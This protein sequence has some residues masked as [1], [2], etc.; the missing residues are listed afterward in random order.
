[1]AVILKNLRPLFWLLIFGVLQ[2]IFIFI[3]CHSKIESA[4]EVLCA[5]F[6][7]I[8]F[9]LNFLSIL[10]LF[11]LLLENIHKK[12]ANAIFLSFAVLWIVLN[13]FDVISFYYLGI[14]CSINSFELFSVNDLANKASDSSIAIKA[15]A[16]LIVFVFILFKIKKEILP[17]FT[18]NKLKQKLLFG[19]IFF[20]LSLT[21]LPYP[22]NYYSHQINISNAAKQLS[23][24]SYYS[25]TKSFLHTKNEYIMNEQE[26]LASFK[27]QQG[28]SNTTDF[29]DREVNYTDMA[30][31]NVVLI[32]M[33]SF[34]ANRIGALNG[35]KHLSPHFDSLCA[36]GTLYTKCFSS[37]PRTQYGISSIFFGFPHILGYNLFRE[38]KLKHAFNGLIKLAEK[39]KYK[40]HFIHGGSAAYDDMELFLSA[41]AALTVKDVDDIKE[42]KFKNTWGVDDESLF[43]FSEKYIADNSGK[44]LFCI[45]SMTNHEPHQVP[46]DFKAGDNIK[47]LEKKESAFLYSD[48]ALG[49]FV[50]KLRHSNKYKNTLIIITGDHAEGYSSRDNETKLFH[51]PLL[52]IDHK[53]KNIKNNMICSHADI[54]EYV[55]SKTKFKGK[56]HFINHNLNN[57]K[58]GQAYYRNYNN[59]IYQVTDS[60]IYR[61]N[62]IDRSFCKLYCDSNMYVTK[63]ERIENIDPKNALILKNMKANY[64]SLQYLF[65]NGMYHAN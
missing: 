21:Y 64:T 48:Q 59:D 38:N 11:Y 19:C 63:Q 43:S 23:L 20:I 3:L 37:G 27:M 40:T 58:S 14:R 45:L 8:I 24:N 6:L 9:D 10:F 16:L 18:S 29:I 4:S 51:V 42:F 1:M 22:I 5:L 53:N 62:L 30:Y 17:D 49:T 39:N 33:E 57:V 52:I 28:Y 41:D 35:D 15:L 56:S 65:E 36:E 50:Q 32:I 44:N 25:W 26:A 55:L 54:A 7:G 61:Y 2:R 31:D 46:A 34:G 13:A 60:V 12:I 47:D